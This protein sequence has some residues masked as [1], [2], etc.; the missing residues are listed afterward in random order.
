VGGYDGIAC[1]SGKAA[2]PIVTPHPP[3]VLAVGAVLIQARSSSTP[4]QRIDV[5]LPQRLFRD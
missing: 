2:V 1:P 3:D 5:Q 4:D